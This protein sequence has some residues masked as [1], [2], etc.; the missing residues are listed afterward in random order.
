MLS[1]R[2]DLH[3]LVLTFSCHPMFIVFPLILTRD[4]CTT[5]DTHMR[6]LRAKL[7][8]DAYA[9]VY[10]DQK[11]EAEAWQEVCNTATTHEK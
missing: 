2:C 3:I 9:K 6:A 10:E 11:R 8:A 7:E 4:A 1:G 5:Q